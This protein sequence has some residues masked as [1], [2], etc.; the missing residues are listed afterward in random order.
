MPNYV[1][2]LRALIHYAVSIL[3]AYA[4][5]DKWR[6]SHVS[7]FLVKYFRSGSPL[8]GLGGYPAPARGHKPYAARSISRSEQ[9]TRLSG[10]IRPAGDG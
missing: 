5:L 10:V 4:Q 9:A 7:A 2:L 3:A 8:L 6:L 1:L